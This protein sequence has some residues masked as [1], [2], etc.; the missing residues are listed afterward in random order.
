MGNNCGHCGTELQGGSIHYCFDS[1]RAE[2]SHLRALNEQYL[3]QIREQAKTIEAVNL[4]AHVWEQERDR[5]KKAL[6]ILGASEK[7]GA[8]V[9]EASMLS[10]QRRPHEQ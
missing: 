10:N 2:I 4:H 7:A 3:G 9:P 6:A 5:Y 1:M 8:E